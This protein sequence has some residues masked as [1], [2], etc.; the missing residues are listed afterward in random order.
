MGEDRAADVLRLLALLALLAW[1]QALMDLGL[2]KL[3]V[4]FGVLLVCSGIY[5]ALPIPT[6]YLHE[7]WA[8]TLIALSLPLQQRGW[9]FSVLAGLAALAFRE[10]ALPFVLVMAFCAGWDGRRAEAAAWLLGILAFAI[11]LALHGVTVSGYLSPEA[12]QGGGWFT[13][14]GWAR[15]LAFNH[16]NLLIPTAS[17]W[18]TVLWVP[19]AL[20]G[21][22]ARQ[23]PLGHR[24]LWVVVGYCLAFF[25]VGRPNNDYWGIVSAPLLAVSLTFTPA[26]LQT[27][28]THALG[29]P[30]GVITS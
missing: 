16:W 13:L 14:G 28:W 15:V 8:S 17:A 23:E 6:I 24:L 4:V 27:L 5:L 21:A 18:L 2:G 3:G 1:V 30:A 19:L 10:L 26:A 20:L 29:K 11:G 25:F 9:P 12:R 22:G 7:I